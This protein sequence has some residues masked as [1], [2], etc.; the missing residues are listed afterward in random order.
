MTPSVIVS[1]FYTISLAFCM[2]GVFRMKKSENVLY[3]AAWIPVSALLVT[4]YQCLFAAL[5]TILHIPVNLLS[6]G[7]ADG[8]LGC[9]L[10]YWIVKKKRI[11]S[12]KF[13]KI[14][15][16]AFSVL[17]LAI[18]L[19]AYHRFGFDMHIHY[20]S[21]DLAQHLK[22]AMDIVSGQRVSA[23][24]Y[25]GFHN[26]L[27]IQLL[28]PFRDPTRY[29]QIYVFG[30]V[31]HLLLA[32]LMFYGVIRKYL[33]DNFLKLASIVIILIYINGYPVN[34]TIFGFTYLGMCVTVI[35]CTMVVVDSFIQDELSRWMGIILISL[36]CLGIFECYVLF[37]PIMFFSVFFCVLYK[38]K[39]LKKLVSMDTVKVCLGIFLVPTI[40][41]LYFTYNGIFGSGG[42][43]VK[44]AIAQEGGIYKDLFSNFVLLM[45]LA[46][47]GYYYLRK[48]KKNWI[49]LYIFPM[50]ACFM[51]ALFGLGM[52]GR[53]SSYYFYKNYYLLWLIV[54]VLAFAGLTYV[55]K[56]SRLLLTLGLLMWLFV[57]LVGICGIE[58]RIGNK[59]ERY[60]T[61]HNSYAFCDIYIFNEDAKRNVCYYGGKVKL[62]Q[63]AMSELH[64]TDTYVALAGSWADYYWMEAITNQRNNDFQYWDKGEDVFF[65]NL[66]N[67][68][69]VIVLTDSDIY[70]SHAKYFNNLEKVYENECGFIAKVKKTEQSRKSGKGKASHKKKEW[71][72]NRK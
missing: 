66:N 25:A 62:Y 28:A 51:L 30:D 22:V 49:I 16:L 23:M 36:C 8:I 69:Y 5:G 43:T 32:G 17:L 3:G 40:L 4:F 67:I 48:E 50:L 38:Q 47:F 41:G 13:E 60:I 14:D 68:D 63:Y 46:L 31:L 61:N 26:A 37:M 6:V 18:G 64:D 54:F 70:H 24:F 71:E 7:I 59:N 44:Y 2:T 72:R 19:F 11:Q 53:V 29:Y 20:Q 9:I 12:Y 34:S 57:L 33:K 27:L 39:K 56:K 65:D 21:I 42:I 55:E 45:P 10:W 15:L 52:S 35:G 1:V 58:S